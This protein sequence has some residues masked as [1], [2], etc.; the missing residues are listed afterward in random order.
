VAKEHSLYREF[1]D[2]V[3]RNIREPVKKGR[4]KKT[5]NTPVRALI[6]K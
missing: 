6:L 2:A 4:R 3:S 1:P 5:A